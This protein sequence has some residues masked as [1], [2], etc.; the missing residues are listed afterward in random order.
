MLFFTS[1]FVKQ[2][3]VLFPFFLAETESFNEIFSS[4]EQTMMGIH[5]IVVLANGNFIFILV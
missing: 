5:K 3:C 2:L 1:Q 4:N